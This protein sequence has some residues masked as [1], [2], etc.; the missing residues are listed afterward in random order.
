MPSNGRIIAQIRQVP[1][2]VLAEAVPRLRP[3]NDVHTELR[4]EFAAWV[5]RYPENFGSWQAAW[6]RWTRSAEGRP[7]RVRLTVPCTQCRGKRF[8][9]RYGAPAACQTCLMRGKEN[10]NTPALWQRP[11]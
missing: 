2:G 6:N 7:G 4:R 9:L 3:F 10:I 11:T 1:F 5:S 8:T